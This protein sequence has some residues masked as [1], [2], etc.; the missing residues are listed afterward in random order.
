MALADA[1]ESGVYKQCR[2]HLGEVA[3][4]TG[5]EF[6]CCLGVECRLAGAP[7]DV[8]ELKM[9]DAR[10]VVKY[11]RA[12]DSSIGFLPREVQSAHGWQGGQ[13]TGLF[14]DG[15]QFEYDGRRFDSLMNMN[16][17]GVPFTVIARAV[18][19]KWEVL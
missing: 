8:Y 10:R 5:E 13:G 19:E 1:L 2:N 11:G 6:N 16:D 7:R 15:S 18:R 9:G 17:A 3:P 4:L 12:I 14:T